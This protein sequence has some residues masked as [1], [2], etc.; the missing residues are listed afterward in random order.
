MTSKLSAKINRNKEKISV[1]KFSKKYVLGLE[2]A[3]HTFNIST[4]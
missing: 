2:M 1:S 4:W 3:A